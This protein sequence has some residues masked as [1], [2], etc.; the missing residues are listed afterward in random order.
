[1]EI[2]EPSKIITINTGRVKEIEE[3]VGIVQ[4]NIE[5][6]TKTTSL[7]GK[8]GTGKT[9]TGEKL[10]ERIGDQ[11]FSLGEIFRYL[12]YLIKLLKKK[13]NYLIMI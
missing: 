2:F 3:V 13:L 4:S 9:T 12:G 11:L 10:K 6:E 7:E 5:E 1:M 8:S